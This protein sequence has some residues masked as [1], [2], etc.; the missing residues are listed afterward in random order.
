VEAMASRLFSLLGERLAGIEEELVTLATLQQHGRFRGPF[1]TWLAIT[2][3]LR[4][5]LPSLIRRLASSQPQ[6]PGNLE[7]H[8][9]SPGIMAATGDLVR[10]EARRVQDLLYTHGLAVGRWHALITTISAEH[11]MTNAG[12]LARRIPQRCRSRSG[13]LA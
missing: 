10:D 4:F 11:L 13:R 3:C 2:D 12:A 5:G 7:S 9:R 8:L 6:A 1:R